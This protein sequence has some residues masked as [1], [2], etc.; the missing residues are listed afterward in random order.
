MK[1]P[2]EYWLLDWCENSEELLV[3]GH[4][5]AAAFRKVAER[6][7]FGD[8]VDD[9]TE[10]RHAWGRW[11]PRLHGYDRYFVTCDGPA[12]GV[13]AFTIRAAAL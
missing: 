7:G 10:V 3:R 1:T 2:R 6:A 11:I 9:D 12:R 13:V 8:M 5:D 4:V